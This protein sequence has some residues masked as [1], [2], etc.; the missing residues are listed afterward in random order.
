MKK[1][2]ATATLALA[3]GLS[4]SLAHAFEP[5]DVYLQAGTHGVGIGYAQPL[6]SWLGVRADVN[7]FGLSHNFSAGDLDYD[8]HLHLFGVGTYVDLFPIRSSG[9]R[10]ST[11]LLFN[12]DYLNGTATPNS[13]GNITI[14]G[15]T[16]HLPNSSV[17][18]RIKEPTVMP[19]LGIGYG[20]K[21][22]AK[23]GL[24]FTADIGVAFGRPRTDFNVSP[25]IAAAAGPENV[26]AEEQQVRNKADKYHI[27][28]IVQIGVSY[29]F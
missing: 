17:N 3:L 13:A 11:G 25:D 29:R 16:Y 26:A 27:Y 5:G 15:T 7:G 28:P 2:F 9:F 24:G 1:R 19:Y 10:L 18:A 14:N 21:P 22:T 12:D 20:H 4:A 6:T 8:A 23:R